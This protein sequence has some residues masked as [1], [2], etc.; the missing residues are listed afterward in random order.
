MALVRSA[1]VNKNSDAGSR[2]YCLYYVTS[3][4]RAIAFSKALFYLECFALQ[5]GRDLGCMGCAQSGHGGER[6]KLGA[7]GG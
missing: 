2:I 4:S 7:P 1:G 5:K 6:E 3:K